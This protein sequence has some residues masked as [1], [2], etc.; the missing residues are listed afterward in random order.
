M[1][2][3]AYI[4]WTERGLSCRLGRTP[5]GWRLLV[6]ADGGEP[7]LRRFAHSRGDATNQAE[8]L[9]L[10][11]GHARD[12]LRTSRKRRPLILIVEDDRENLSAYEETLAAQGFRTAAATTLADARR[13][14]REIEPAAILLD[15][16]LPDGE[17]TALARELRA[18][19]GEERVPIVLLTG[20]DPAAVAGE[21]A[22]GADAV[23]G[24]PCRPETLTGVLKLVVQRGG[25]GMQG[26]TAS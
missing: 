1:P 5:E 12:G 4:L 7:F 8:Y 17:G 9:R 22:G 23:L 2:G 11:L 24:K 21:Y 13:L 16:V 15:H 20:R 14:L 6:E 25:H 10:L 18:S 19:R 3:N 26:M